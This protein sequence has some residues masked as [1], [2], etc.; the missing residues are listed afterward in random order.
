M[1]SSNYWMTVEEQNNFKSRSVSRVRALQALYAIEFGLEELSLLEPLLHLN[2]EP[3][4]VQLI[5][6]YLQ[7][8]K[9]IDSSISAKLESW[10][11]ER[12]NSIDRNILRLGASELLLGE[13]DRA[14]IINEY[15]EIAKVYGTEKSAIFVNG[16]LD[17]F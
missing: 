9:N 5:D 14:I 15:I 17:S 6:Y 4:A 7:Y 1:L 16:L 2:Q 8:K 3:F 10:S 11:L 13:T 12:L